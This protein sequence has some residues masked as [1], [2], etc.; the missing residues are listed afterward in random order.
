MERS[1]NT[2]SE[3]FS[4]KMFYS[5][6]SSAEADENYCFTDIDV[7]AY[8]SNSDS[9]VFKNSNFGQRFLNIRMQLP[10]SVTFE[11]EDVGPQ[12]FV[13]EGKKLD[14]IQTEIYP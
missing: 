2:G 11:Y 8:G 12:Q 10:K 7:G 6:I 14:Y 9:S 13:F 1:E 4:N 3:A 5:L